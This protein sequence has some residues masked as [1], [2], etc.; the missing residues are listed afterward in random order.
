MAILHDQ[1]NPGFLPGNP[2]TSA[3]LHTCRESGL[4]RAVLPFGLKLLSS[5]GAS[6]G[7]FGRRSASQSF[8]ADILCPDAPVTEPAAPS[9]WG[10]LCYR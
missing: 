5:E 2:W 4:V 1:R 8:L 7:G 6:F 10:S 9:L 3:G